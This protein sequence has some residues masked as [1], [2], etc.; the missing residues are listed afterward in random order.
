MILSR[1]ISVILSVSI[2]ALS[3]FFR[4]GYSKTN[5]SKNKIGLTIGHWQPNLLINEKPA[6]VFNGTAN[7]LPYLS[8]NYD[9]AVWG[10]VNVHL[11]VGY[12]A[13]RYDSSEPKTTLV[14]SPLEF[15]LE[16]ELVDNFIV[17]PYVL[18]GAGLLLGKCETG[19]R[20]KEVNINHFT[21][22]G[23]DLFLQTGLRIAPVSSFEIDLNLGYLYAK[24]PKKIGSG[25][26]YSGIRATI[27]INYLF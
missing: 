19:N 3:L 24:F 27:G 2:L 23:L 16:H 11:S 8:I 18:Y 5:G 4:P 20:L 6:S 15:G 7:S 25:T 10:N 14:I 12:W 1:K 13:H 17:T 21:Q 9:R 22:T 26:D